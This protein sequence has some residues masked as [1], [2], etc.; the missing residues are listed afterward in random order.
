MQVEQEAT[1]KYRCI[2]PSA[3]KIVYSLTSE[4]AQVGSAAWV[5]CTSCC[6]KRWLAAPSRTD[7]KGRRASG[8]RPVNEASRD[9]LNR[10]TAN[11]A[12]LA[13][14]KRMPR[15]SQTRA[16]LTYMDHGV[17]G[18]GMPYILVG[19]ALGNAPNTA[20]TKGGGR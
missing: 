8:L 2:V 4:L 10:A 13:Q 19:I 1:F 3:A 6:K 9:D 12:S 16:I 7:A 15:G 18:R 14:H 11:G 17:V 20:P 5:P